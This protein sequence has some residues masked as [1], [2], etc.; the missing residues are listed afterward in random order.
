VVGYRKLKQAASDY[1][2]IHRGDT[3][4]LD[5]GT[6]TGKAMILFTLK[7]NKRYWGNPATY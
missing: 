5:K 6:G 7:M 4:T 1:G 2:K 3:I